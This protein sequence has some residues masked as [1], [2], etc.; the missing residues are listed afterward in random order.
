MKSTAHW[1]IIG[2]VAT[3]IIIAT[4]PL[5]QWRIEHQR[6]I[7]N[8]A[9][10][11]VAPTFTGSQKCAECHKPQYDGWKGSHHDLAMDVA[12][13]ETVLGDFNGAL[14]DYFGTQSRFYRKEDQFWVRTQGPGGEMADFQIQYVFGVYPLQQYLVPFPGGRLQCLPIAWD[15]R[16]KRWYHLNPDKPVNPTDWL[17]WT[18]AGQNWNGMCAECHS[19]NL[20]KNYDPDKGTYQTTWSEID[21]GCE[22]CHGPGSRH[23]AWAE[24]PAMARPQTHD[25]YALTVKTGGISARDQVELCAPC[26]GRRAIL[27]DYTH[28]EKDLLDSLLPT[29]LTEGLY[30]PDGQILDEVYVYGSFTQSKMYHRNVRCSDCHDVHSVKTVKQDN[31]LCLQCHKAA[32][33]DTKAHHFHKQAGETGDPIKDKDGKVLFEVGSGAQ[34]VQCHMPGR[35]YMVID[36]RP[37]HSFR[38]PRPDLSLRLDT[39]NACNRCHRDK[40]RQWA[41]DAMT[42]WYG[43]GRADHYGTILG[44]GRER[45]PGAQ[46]QLIQLA[47]DALYPVIVRATA[48]SLLRHYPGRETQHALIKAI[49]DPEALIRHT[50]LSRF[51]LIAPDNRRIKLLT[52]MLYDPVTAIRMEAANQVAAAGKAELFSEAEAVYQTALSAYEEAMAYS[53]DFSFGRFNLGNLYSN[54]KQ[55]DRAMNQYRAAISIDSQFYPAKVNLA[56]LYNQKGDNAEAEKLFI[57]VLAVRSDLYEVHYSLG[58][59]LAEEKRY[60]EAAKYLETAS[61]GMPNYARVHYNA[62]QIWDYLN[63]PDKAQAALERSYRL[64]PQNPDYLNALVRYYVKHGQ[65]SQVNKTAQR[66]LAQDPQNAVGLKLRQLAERLAEEAGK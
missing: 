25:N 46:R 15:A 45:R 63:R 34:C 59:L 31:A 32:V 21:V 60:A 9:V 11:A 30:Y 57:D 61:G 6:S 7:G 42:K 12:A 14:F 36:Y 5:Y 55:T 22:A 28:Y 39:P 27:G 58:L 51:D 3:L 65:F 53:A 8:V 13:E 52:A 35:N 2:I 16:Q 43:P 41:D 40:S 37:D 49:D 50:A 48:L 66:I 38:I 62:G 64:E 29:L 4:V 44:A 26:H 18:N 54:L 17:Y 20:K 1:K 10:K 47:G 56:M 24:L 23:V 19:T 33:Y